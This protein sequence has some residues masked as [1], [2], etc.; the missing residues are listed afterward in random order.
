MKSTGEVMGIDEQFSIAFA[1]S[2]VAAGNALPREGTVFISLA[3]GDKQAFIE[4]AQVLQ[5]LGYKLIGTQGTA[6][7]LGEAGVAIES[8]R[9]LQEGRPNL[10]DY[11]ANGDVQLIFN[12]PSGKGARTDEGRI[13]SAAVAAGVPCVTTLSGVLAAVKALEALKANP[14]PK[15]KALQDWLA[16]K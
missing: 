10:L 4:G 7:V 3:K 15:V 2:Q 14:V 8:V 13:R 11:M 12:T 1:K 5:A 6:R 9:K 16:T